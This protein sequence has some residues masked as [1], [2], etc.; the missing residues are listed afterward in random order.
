MNDIQALVIKNELNLPQERV[1][2]LVN[3]LRQRSVSYLSPEKEGGPFLL[4]C[5]GDD[6][7]KVALKTNYP[8]EV[9]LLTAMQYRWN[10]KASLLQ[11]TLSDANLLDIQ[12]DMAKML[13][14]AT[15]TT[16]QKELGDV[17]AGRLDP[18]KSSL[19]PKTIK[20]LNELMTMV[21]GI[22]DKIN[23]LNNPPQQPQAAITVQAT[24]VQINQGV[25]QPKKSKLDR[26]KELESSE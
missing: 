2:S 16:I 14:I 9:I 20:G 6:L 25:E 1:N 12:K 11:K 7:E 23:D 8:I 10:T 19:I 22:T 5:C 3:S 4:Y 21:N 15:H 24:N 18:N 17:I 13:L 26:L